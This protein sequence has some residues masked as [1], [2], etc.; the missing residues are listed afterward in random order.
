MADDLSQYFA[1][2]M[3]GQVIRAGFIQSEPKVYGATLTVAVKAKASMTAT[4]ITPDSLGIE[5]NPEAVA[6]LGLAGVLWEL[7]THVAPIVG[8]VMAI[9]IVVAAGNAC[10][11][12][13][14]KT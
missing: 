1:E 2:Q 12:R 10:L 6:L 8:P 5:V 4:V 13:R 9:A 7:Y 11:H 3:R 14:A